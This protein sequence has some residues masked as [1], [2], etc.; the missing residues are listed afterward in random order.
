MVKQEGLTKGRSRSLSFERETPELRVILDVIR[1]HADVEGLEWPEQIDWERFLQLLEIH[2]LAPI[3][4]EEFS[5]LSNR[6]PSSIA[7][8]IQDR[9]RA[10]ALRNLEYLGELRTLDAGFRDRGVPYLLLKGPALSQDLYGNPVLRPYI[11]LD[12]LVQPDDL[13][14]ARDL[15][16]RSGFQRRD[17][18]PKPGHRPY[19]MTLQKGT[20][21]VE[22]HWRL[23]HYHEEWLEDLE[24]VFRQSKEV[25]LPGFQVSTLADKDCLKFLLLHGAY[26]R[27]RRLK[28]LLDVQRLGS[29]C[30][31]RLI[32]EI[33]YDAEERN[34]RTRLETG[35]FL[36]SALFD[37]MM[38]Y[39]IDDLELDVQLQDQLLRYHST[40]WNANQIS[41]SGIVDRFLLDRMYYDSTRLS[42]FIYH[43]LFEP[44]P[45]DRVWIQLPSYLEWLY[46][47]LRP[48]RLAAVHT[49]GRLRAL[50][51]GVGQ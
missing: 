25:T 39:S 45:A 4:L 49:K 44:K 48:L 46:P 8:A 51:S 3:L 22:L 40:I 15:M 9:A 37:S 29:K 11:D 50:V 6:F 5:P 2:Q 20:L 33:L 21:T 41:R 17:N 42:T 34:D 14:E 23:S 10:V 1:S 38:P 36:V 18:P 43:S 7:S 19:H 32:E 27:W 30:E 47:V 12:I 13:S 35:L 24:R 28:W 16:E 26:H 31:S